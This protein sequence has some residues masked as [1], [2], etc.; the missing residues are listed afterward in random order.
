MSGS[1]IARIFGLSFRLALVGF[2]LF[3]AFFAFRSW[4]SSFTLLEPSNPALHSYWIWERVETVLSYTSVGLFAVFSFSLVS[5]VL[6]L[7]SDFKNWSKTN[8]TGSVTG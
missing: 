4:W 8:R 6:E 1:D 3:L 2:G 5:S 7:N